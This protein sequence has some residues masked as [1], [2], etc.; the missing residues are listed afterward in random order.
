MKIT[1]DNI[2]LQLDLLEATADQFHRCQIN[3]L[4]LPCTYAKLQEKI[5]AVGYIL[6]DVDDGKHITMKDPTFQRLMVIAKNVDNLKH[7]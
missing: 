6:H 2:K 5:M 1:L 3:G 4:S 7:R